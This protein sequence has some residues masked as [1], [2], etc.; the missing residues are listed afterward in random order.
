M[1]TG[2]VR[3]HRVLNFFA[4]GR[5]GLRTTRQLRSGHDA[6]QRELA[7]GRIDPVDRVAAGVSHVEPTLGADIHTVEVRIDVCSVGVV[8]HLEGAEFGNLRHC[9]GGQID[10]ENA[11][12]VLERLQTGQS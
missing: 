2:T 8:L 3:L 9:S 6:N 10:L 12:L 5:R 1:P 11:V 4:R 7:G